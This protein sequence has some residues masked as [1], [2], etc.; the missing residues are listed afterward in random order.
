LKENIFDF[1]VMARGYFIREIPAAAD[2][3]RRITPVEAERLQGFPDDWTRA[4]SK[5]PG[6]GLPGRVTI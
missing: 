3:L 5:A 1:D 6:R 4:L 2:L